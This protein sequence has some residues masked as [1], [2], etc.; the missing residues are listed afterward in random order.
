MP[1][2]PLF[3]V[4]FEWGWK[5]SILHGETDTSHLL[6]FFSSFLQGYAH[7]RTWT[8]KLSCQ[9]RATMISSTTFDLIRTSLID[10]TSDLPLFHHH[11]LFLRIDIMVLVRKT[12]GCMTF[13]E[14]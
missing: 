8:G 4:P 2:P 3:S 10:E 13:F 14:G 7:C 9:A 11:I 1:L 12:I 6:L 5:S